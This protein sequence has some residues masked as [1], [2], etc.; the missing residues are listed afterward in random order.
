M[1]NRKSV[2]ILMST[3]NGEKYLKAQ[4]DSIIAQKNIN[5][6]FLI[7]DDGSSDK[8]VSILEEY[9][10]KIANLK[11]YCGDNLGFTYS[12]YDLIH[13][14]DLNYDFYAC[15]DQDDIWME[16]KLERAINQLETSKALLYASNMYIVD[17]NLVGDHTLYENYE[18]AKNLLIECFPFINPFGCTIVYSK[19]LQQILI[20]GLPHYKIPHDLWLHITANFNG[21]IIIDKYPTI[22]HRVHDNNA[23]GIGDSIIERINKLKKFYLSDSRITSDIAAQEA[24][25]LFSTNNLSKENHNLITL[26]I[27]YRNNLY[28]KFKLC[29]AS[30]FKI[31]KFRKRIEFYFLILIGK[32]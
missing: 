2:L 32:F 17:S 15:A 24:I 8:T 27:N 3:Y 5:V 9:S 22:R 1:Q 26:I 11:Y 12:F 31:I 4:L 13:N 18:Y 25:R 21:N 19:K 23:C 20:K 28:S 16:D 29:C 30:Q 7:R 14:A 10:N 6:H